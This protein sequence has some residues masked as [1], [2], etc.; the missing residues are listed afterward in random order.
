MIITLRLEVSNRTR[1]HTRISSIRLDQYGKGNLVRDKAI[2]K[3]AR[4][5]R[6]FE[7]TL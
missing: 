4:Y 2:F 6:D 1:A 7:I 3:L 5:K